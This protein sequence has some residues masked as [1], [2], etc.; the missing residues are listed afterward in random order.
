M[1]E[2]VCQ[3]DRYR[4]TFKTASRTE[5]L[6][7]IVALLEGYDALQLLRLC[8]TDKFTWGDKIKQMK[9]RLIWKYVEIYMSTVQIQSDI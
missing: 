3:Q 9:A 6:E 5:G 1:W 4:R 2:F 7:G 8:I